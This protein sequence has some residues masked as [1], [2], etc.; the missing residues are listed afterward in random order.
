MAAVRRIVTVMQSEYK[1][2][3]L[4]PSPCPAKP[5]RKLPADPASLLRM[6]PACQVGPCDDATL[7]SM[8]R[9]CAP[10]LSH[11]VLFCLN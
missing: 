5:Y 7:D 11:F 3:S 1:E 8:R 10:C 9:T 6:Q 2:E 4:L